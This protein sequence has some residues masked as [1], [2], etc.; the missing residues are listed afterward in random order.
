MRRIGS[1]V[2]ILPCRDVTILHGHIVALLGKH[3]HLSLYEFS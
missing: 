2:G 3:G 1:N